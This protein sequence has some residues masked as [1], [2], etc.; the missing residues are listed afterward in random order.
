[1]AGCH[2]NHCALQGFLGLSLSW[3]GRQQDM[4][5]LIVLMRKLPPDLVCYF[6]QEDNSEQ[7]VFGRHINAGGWLVCGLCFSNT[8]GS[9]VNTSQIK[10]SCSPWG[11]WLLGGSCAPGQWRCPFGGHG[12]VEQLLQQCH[13]HRVP[14]FLP[15]H[16]GCGIR[17]LQALL[18]AALC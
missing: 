4:E 5:L 2:S 11:G 14:P 8:R 15:V 18:L 6:Q 13:K 3:G 17:L 9:P 16:P 12:K 10:P 1:M 7:R